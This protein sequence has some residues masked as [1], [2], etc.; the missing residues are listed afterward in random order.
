MSA[1]YECNDILRNTNEE[2]KNGHVVLIKKQH[3]F[4]YNNIHIYI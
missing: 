4:T 3:I 1:G 2:K